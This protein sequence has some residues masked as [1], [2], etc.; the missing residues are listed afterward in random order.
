MT[1]LKLIL[2][3]VN[4]F[5][6]EYARSTSHSAYYIN[7]IY[8]IIHILYASVSSTRRRIFPWW[9]FL[10]ISNFQV[11]WQTLFNLFPPL[12]IPSKFLRW[13]FYILLRRVNS[14]WCNVLSTKP[15]QVREYIESKLYLAV[16]ELSSFLSKTRW[17]TRRR[18][19]SPK[20][21]IC[22]AILNSLLSL[23]NQKTHNLI[24]IEIRIVENIL[25]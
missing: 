10:D 16:V 25:K 23:V 20:P 3:I 21:F 9:H 2:L 11:T 19:S 7:I 4:S 17:R 24:P 22:T 8:C 13:F 12:Q 1:I 6:R 15:Y 14:T 18:L 5:S